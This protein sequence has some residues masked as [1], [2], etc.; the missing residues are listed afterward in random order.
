[1]R[2]HKPVCSCLQGFEGNPE[3]ECVKGNCN[4]YNRYII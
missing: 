3:L 4:N 2:D 1:V